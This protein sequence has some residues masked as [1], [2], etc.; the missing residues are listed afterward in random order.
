MCQLSGSFRV[1]RF[2]LVCGLHLQIVT[3]AFDKWRVSHSGHP[4]S[5]LWLGVRLKEIYILDAEQAAF[6]STGPK[7]LNCGRQTPIF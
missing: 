5:N 1:F 4:S 3:S 6:A 2:A 7:H